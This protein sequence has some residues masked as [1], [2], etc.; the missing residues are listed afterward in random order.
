MGWLVAS[1]ESFAAR[2]AMRAKIIAY[3]ALRRLAQM[4][5][6]LVAILL[7]DSAIIYGLGR[8]EK[9][10]AAVRQDRC[11]KYGENLPDQMGGYCGG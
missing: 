9:A 6:V 3:I 8:E 4:L 10:R 2:V 1:D 11:E 5:L 7:L